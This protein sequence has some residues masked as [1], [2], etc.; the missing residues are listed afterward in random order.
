LGNN[1]G[2]VYKWG[3]LHTDVIKIKNLFYQY[4]NVKLCLAG[5]LHMQEIIEYLGVKYV[6]GGAVSGNWWK[7]NRFEFAPAFSVVELFAD[8]SSNVQFITY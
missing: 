2:E 7:G 3:L 8:G 5:H 1:V 6:C 4:P